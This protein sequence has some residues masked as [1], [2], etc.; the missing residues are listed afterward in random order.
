MFYQTKVVNQRGYRKQGIQHS[1][2][3]WESPWGWYWVNQ[4]DWR[5]ETQDMDM[6]RTVITK[7]T[8]P[9]CNLYNQF[10]LEAQTF[11]V[12]WLNDRDPTYWLKENYTNTVAAWH[13][14]LALSWSCCGRVSFPPWTSG[15][16]SVSVKD[17]LC[18]FHVS[19][20]LSVPLWNL[21]FIVYS[22]MGFE[23]CIIM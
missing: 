1:G 8:L 13:S 5:R 10:S 2:E 15:S 11:E 7:M 23:K 19:L 4:E 17:R 14:V 21:F 16:S 22:S 3:V 9:L 20:R 18:E 6:L 12:N